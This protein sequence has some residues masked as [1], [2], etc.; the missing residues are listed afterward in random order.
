MIWM[1]TTLEWKELVAAA[2]LVA[3]AGVVYWISE[4]RKASGSGGV[5]RL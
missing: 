1:L 3:T 2:G 5:P 4:Q